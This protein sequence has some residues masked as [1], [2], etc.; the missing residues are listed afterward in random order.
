MLVASKVMLAVRVS[1]Q[2]IGVTSTL[3]TVTI[4]GNPK[5]V[6]VEG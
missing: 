5:A 2:Y 6:C 1:G 4:P 3:L